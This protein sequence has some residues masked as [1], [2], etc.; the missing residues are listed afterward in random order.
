MQMKIDQSIRLNTL[1]YNLKK[2][3]KKKDKSMLIL[4]LIFVKDFIRFP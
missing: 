3:E 2:K 1:F 4:F